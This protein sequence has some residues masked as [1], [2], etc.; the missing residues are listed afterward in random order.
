MDA[1]F[2]YFGVR[3][4]VR[5]EWLHCVFKS[6]RFL[7]F[8]ITFQARSD[9][10]LPLGKSRGVNHVLTHYLELDEEPLAVLVP[11]GYLPMNLQIEK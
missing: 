1:Y 9:L 8:Y 2:S 7:V 3:F 4:G 5:W 10:S 11:P 6:P